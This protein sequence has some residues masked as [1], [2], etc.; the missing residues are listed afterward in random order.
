MYV[1][2]LSCNYFFFFE[3]LTITINNTILL[4]RPNINNDNIFLM[5]V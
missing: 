2:R 3:Q 5:P 1:Q 4:D